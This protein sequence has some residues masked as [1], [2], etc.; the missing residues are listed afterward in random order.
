[1]IDEEHHPFWC[2]GG[3]S[4]TRGRHHGGEPSFSRGIPPGKHGGRLQAIL[5][6]QHQ[7]PV[8]N[9]GFCGQ[10]YP[11]RTA[12][13]LLYGYR[14]R[15]RRNFQGI[16]VQ[17]Q[18]EVKADPVQFAGVLPPG[19]QDDVAENFLRQHDFTFTL[20]RGAIGGPGMV[21]GRQGKRKAE[22]E[23]RVRAG[24]PRR[25]LNIDGHGFHR[26]D[27]AHIQVD[28]PVPVLLCQC[29]KVAIF[30]TFFVG[31]PGFFRRF[32]RRLDIEALA[33]NTEPAHGR[34]AGQ[35]KRVDRLKR[36]LLLRLERVPHHQP[37]AHRQHRACKPQF[38]HG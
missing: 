7:V 17:R 33:Y 38:L 6:F 14:M 15:W 16:T 3:G 30:Q 31:L 34:V 18:V 37:R 5:R 35:R 9:V 11:R 26:S 4:E 32:Q 25:N 20:L 36:L 22:P 19:G 1:M 12:G 28:Q 23:P 27:I 29:G 21:S 2:V 13:T 24:D 8:G 10:G